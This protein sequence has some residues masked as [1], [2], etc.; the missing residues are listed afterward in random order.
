MTALVLLPGLLC[1]RAVFEPMLPALATHAQCHIPHYHDERSLAAMAQRALHGAPERFALLGHSMGG[2]VALEILRSAPERVER[3]ALLDTGYEP[4]EEGEAGARER[5]GRLEM[6][7]VA[8]TQGMRAM[9]RRWV[10]R[11]V[12]P[13]RL[14]DAALIDA[15]LDMVERRNTVEFA[16]QIQ[17]LLTRPDAWSVLAALRVPALVLCGRE[18]GWSPL[19]RHEDMAARIPGARLAVIDRCGHMCTM[20]QPTMVADAVVA[21]LFAPDRR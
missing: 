6:L 11:M 7:E 1:D 9:G 16:A 4:L 20:E 3:V 19:A 13:D 14:D 21:W 12:H 8:R 10:Q 15:I 18:D 2:R 17:A 5:A